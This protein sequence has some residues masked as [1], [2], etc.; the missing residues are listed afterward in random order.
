MSETGTENYRDPGEVPVLDWID[1]TLIDIDPDYQ[2]GLDDGRVSRIVEW[3]DWSS[4]GAIV[5]A[6]VPDTGRY[7]CTDGQHR[8]AAAKLHPAVDVVPAVIIPVSGKVAEASNF[9]AINRDRRNSTALDRYWAELAAE[10]PEAVT[11][12]QVCERAGVSIQRYPALDYKPGQ[13]VAVSA[14]RA[15]VDKWGAMRGREI[16]QVLAKAE[17]MP[18]KGEQIRAAEILLTDDEFRHDVEPEAL[19]DAISD[20]AEEFG[21]EAKAF[22]KTH[23]LPAAKAFASV[24]FRRCKKRRKT[25]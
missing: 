17:L 25:G 22:A 24:W 1:K 21:M 2:R 9:I 6:P 18:I 20:N 13:T 4:F 23:R 8:L 15:V 11:I 12:K 10:D 5:V 16:L 14:I 7:H 19:S 3:F